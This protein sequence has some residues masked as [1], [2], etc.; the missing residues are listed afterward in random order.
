[1]KPH[2]TG[3]LWSAG[4]FTL[5]AAATIKSATAAAFQRSGA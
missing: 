5:A 1:V 2:F 3:C 4:S